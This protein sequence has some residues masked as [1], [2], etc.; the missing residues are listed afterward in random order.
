MTRRRHFPSILHTMGGY[1]LS[2][3]AQSIRRAKRLHAD[4]I[5]LPSPW[6]SKE[7]MANILARESLEIETLDP[8]INQARRQRLVVFLDI[9][10]Q[11]PRNRG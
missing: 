4:A 7:T 8:S 6:S 11:S 2:D 9:N 10:L 3:W 5:L 1:Q